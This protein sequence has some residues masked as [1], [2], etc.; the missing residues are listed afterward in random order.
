MFVYISQYYNY[1]LEWNFESSETFGL[2]RLNRNITW[3]KCTLTVL[4]YH[5][6]I[7]A[8]CAYEDMYEW[9][10]KVEFCCTSSRFSTFH[11][12]IL[13]VTD[14]YIFLLFH[15]LLPDQE[16]II[17]AAY[18]DWHSFPKISMISCRETLWHSTTSL[19]R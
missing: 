10:V 6:L 16:P 18:F 1:F 3:I 11:Y 8:L 15:R 13:F 17:C 12:W 9:F 5:F 19:F 7:N 4:E 2:S 14:S